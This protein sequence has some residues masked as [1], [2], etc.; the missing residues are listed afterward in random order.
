MRI[1]LASPFF[2]EVSREVV[3]EI[4]EV[5]EKAE[6]KVFAPMRDGI[7]CPKDASWEKRQEV[8]KLD[9]QA[10]FDSELVV[11]L[12]DYPLPIT[13]QLFLHQRTPDGPDRLVAIELPDP[14]TIFEIGFMAALQQQNPNSSWKGVVGF[15]QNPKGGF[16]L[17]IEQACLAVVKNLKD[18]LI[19]L[20]YIQCEDWVG[21]HNWI[22]NVQKKKIQSL[23]EY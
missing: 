8:F 20:V 15:T 1:Y 21:L 17:M 13:E 19:V 18:L 6:H 12:L 10:I 16:N 23:Q 14:G 4:L 7:M 11:A 3:A 22:R 9:C 2:N 5:L